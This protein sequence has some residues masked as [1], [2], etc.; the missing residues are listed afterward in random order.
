MSR[1]SMP[2]KTTAARRTKI[3]ARFTPAKKSAKKRAKKSVAKPAAKLDSVEAL[4]AAGTRALVLP[5]DLSWHSGVA[6]NLQLLFTHAARIDEF[7][8]D[9]D[10]EPA[11]V[12]RG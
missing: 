3:P 1:K 12:F 2:R 10:T 11:P 9:D 4:V 6:R 7:V 5:M 8:L